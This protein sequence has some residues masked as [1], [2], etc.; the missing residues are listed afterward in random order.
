MT[1][2]AAGLATNAFSR[3]KKA[4]TKF[5]NK[6]TVFS[7]NLQWLNY[8]GVAQI[9][10]QIGFDG[11]DLTV[12]PNGHVE[13]ERVLTDLP[14]AVNTIRKRGLDVYSVTTAITDASESYAENIVGLLRDLG[15]SYYRL[16]WFEYDRIA[17][18]EENLSR[19]KRRMEGLAKMNE[20]YGVHGAYQNH[21]GTSFGASIWDL[22]LAVK[23]L[24]PQF[25]GC[26]FDVRHAMVEGGNSWVNDF[27]II[28][29]YI[30]TVNI[31][32]FVWTQTGG[33]WEAQSVGL[34]EGMVNFPK[35]LDMLRL[36]DFK[37]PM[38]MHF[39]YPLGGADQG[40]TQLSIPKEKVS[41]A[42]KKDL[43]R[44]RE[45]LAA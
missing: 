1:A 34:G 4:P 37:G 20:R 32:D 23:D 8:D 11:I 3:E 17:S 38:C 33:K 7:K 45:W 25:I 21:S 16:N 13:P 6:I 35:Y 29:P 31:K 42:M 27:N 44:F 19:M 36:H 5:L 39:E 12:R 15:I 26:Q 41:E 30:R 28:Q 2:V 10:R 14:V 43:V 40:A 24:D 9:A 18:M 22:W